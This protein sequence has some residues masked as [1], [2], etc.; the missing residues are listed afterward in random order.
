MHFL[1]TVC[2]WECFFIKIILFDIGGKEHFLFIF[3]LKSLLAAATATATA[4][5]LF[6][7]KNPWCRRRRR[8]GGRGGWLKKI[9][10]EKPLGR[11]GKNCYKPLC[12]RQRKKI[13][14]MLVNGLILLISGV[15]SGLRAF[16]KAGLLYYKMAVENTIPRNAM[17][18]DQH[19]CDKFDH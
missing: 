19:E 17:I 8:R 5:I 14:A 16:C 7:P 18:I 6:L 3:C 4:A 11:G 2:F 1:K 12:Q 15:A 13:S 10:A 9:N